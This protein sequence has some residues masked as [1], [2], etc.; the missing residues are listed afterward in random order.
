MKESIIACSNWI[1]NN[2]HGPHLYSETIPFHYYYYFSGRKPVILTAELAVGYF[3]QGQ[4]ITPKM[5]CTILEDAVKQN[6][7]DYIVLNSADPE[8]DVKQIPGIEKAFST[9]LRHYGLDVFIV[10]GSEVQ[11]SKFNG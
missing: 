1:R 4:T 9:G 5:V 6:Q 11:S 10:R 3:T 8:L 7:V 2:Y